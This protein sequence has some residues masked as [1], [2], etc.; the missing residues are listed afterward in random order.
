[1][2]LLSTRAFF[3]LSLNFTVKNRD[4][5]STVQSWDILLYPQAQTHSHVYFRC[6]A[7]S[8]SLLFAFRR[9]NCKLL[10][11]FIEQHVP[12]AI[13]LLS[14]Y[15][16]EI[17]QETCN[18]PHTRDLFSQLITQTTPITQEKKKDSNRKSS[19]LEYFDRLKVVANLLDHVPEGCLGP[20]RVKGKSLWLGLT[21]QSPWKPLKNGAF[22]L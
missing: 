11:C 15:K 2:E 22:W 10:I 21:G 17:I 14:A 12:K 9:L 19:S 3:N 1:M 13:T 7:F 8:L 5:L 20:N 18:Q 6:R 16:I 4:T